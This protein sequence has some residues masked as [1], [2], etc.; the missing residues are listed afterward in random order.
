[1]THRCKISNWLVGTKL[2]ASGLGVFL[3]GALVYG[4]AAAQNAAQD[5]AANP[6][7]TPTLRIETG[8]HN[9]PLRIG[10]DAQCRL[11]VTGSTDK[12]VRLWSMPDGKL[13]RT[14][15]VPIGPGTGG[16][17]YAVAAS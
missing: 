3:V 7:P 15:R 17:V 10:T 6:D 5:P 2:R 1:M 4:S 9:A 14:L 16:R 12:T 13:L 11:L 8:M